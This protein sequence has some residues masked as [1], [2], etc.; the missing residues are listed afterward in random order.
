MTLTI[1][2]TQAERSAT[3]RN[4]LIDAAI[5]CLHR[6]GYAATTTTLIVETAQVSRGAMLHQFP[7]K[8]DLL[9]AVAERVFATDTER[10]L[11]SIR[12]LTDPG[13]IADRLIDT[14]WQAF[15]E[16]GA[17]AMLELWLASRSDP[18]LAE[19]FIP[20]IAG[21]DK[22]ARRMIGEIART[23]GMEDEGKLIAI[24]RYFIA[25]L[26]GLSLEWTLRQD[27]ALHDVIKVMK[28]YT[29]W[30]IADSQPGG[31]PAA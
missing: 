29:R 28:A 19:A 16:P 26:R 6:V 15:R 12:G 18:E 30:L 25:T 3:T 24:H 14:A 13:E 4:K 5:D 17:V 20:A 31:K 22:N 27:P 8:A 1:R 23:F 10:Y 21:V 11:R 2:R 9:A 7:T